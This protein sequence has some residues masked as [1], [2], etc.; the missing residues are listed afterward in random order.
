MVEPLGQDLEAHPILGPLDEPERLPQ[1][2]G[3]IISMIQIDRSCPF[4]Y[5]GID[6][7]NGEWLPGLATR[8]KII[9]VARPNLLKVV[10][11]GLVDGLVDHEDVLLARLV[12]PYGDELP[13]FERFHVLYLHHE[14]VSRA[15]A[16]IDSHGKE[17]QIPWRPGQKLFYGLDVLASPDGVNPDLPSLL[18]MIGISISFHAA[19]LRAT[20]A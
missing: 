14:E 13:G 7:L 20:S 10:S 3:P 12:F 2:V 11:K 19:P 8:K 4:L 18:G 9:V 16:V 5:Q 6:G 17:Q 15:K 1:G